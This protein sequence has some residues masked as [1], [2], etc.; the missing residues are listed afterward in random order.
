MYR[1]VNRLLLIITCAV[2]SIASAAG[3][4]TPPSTVPT[5]EATPQA[6]PAARGDDAILRELTEMKA[7]IAQLETALKAQGAANGAEAD[8]QALH[9][10][11]AA[12]T[13]AS[14]STATAAPAQP[15]AT[16]ASPEITPAARASM[17]T[18]ASR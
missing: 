16:P 6:L 1:N 9:A 2:M 13:G 5:S 7:R 4:Q 14:T 3:E 8:A 11:T 18:I 10:A 17:P 15:A 12:T